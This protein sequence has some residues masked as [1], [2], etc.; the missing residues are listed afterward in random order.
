[1]LSKSHF[2]SRNIRRSL[3]INIFGLGGYLILSVA[4]L[5]TVILPLVKFAVDIAVPPY[6]G[7]PSLTMIGRAL[8]TSVLLAFPSLILETI[9]ALHLGRLLRASRAGLYLMLCFCAPI[10]FGPTVCAL[11]WKVLFESNSGLIAMILGTIGIPFPEWSQSAFGTRVFIVA[12][13]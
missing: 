3:P 13:L 8:V 5:T 12:L 11:L 2:S 7:R 1:M 6:I 10:F 9:I 4:L